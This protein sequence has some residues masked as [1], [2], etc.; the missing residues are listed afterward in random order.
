MAHEEGT[1]QPADEGPVERP[2]RP[3][4]P[5]R[6]AFERWVLS[7]G[8]SV[9][10][11]GAGEYRSSPTECAW[12]AWQAA[13]AAA[14]IPKDRLA[15]NVQHRDCHKAADAFWAYWNENGETHKRGYYEST[16]GA[17]NQALR[18]VGVVEHE[19]M[20]LTAAVISAARS[21]A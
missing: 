17:I 15:L 13:T 9:D 14:A 6:A 7:H 8:G 18:T 12:Q 21:R 16:W 3:A 19:H 10:W 11:I 4:D 20:R 1:T 5:E 2:V